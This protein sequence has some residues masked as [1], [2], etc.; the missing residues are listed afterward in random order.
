MGFLPSFWPS[1][2][3]HLLLDPLFR[4]SFP[5]AS[6]CHPLNC[7]HMPH[8]YSAPYN[9]SYFHPPSFLTRCRITNINLLIHSRI[10]FSHYVQKPQSKIDGPDQPEM[11]SNR[12]QSSVATSKNSHFSCPYLDHTSFFFFFYSPSL[13]SGVSQM[14]S[15]ISYCLSSP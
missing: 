9:F 8:P 6:I 1:F 7:F 14:S 12:F 15:K 2:A 11:Y 13:D 3:L 5:T 10:F 4:G